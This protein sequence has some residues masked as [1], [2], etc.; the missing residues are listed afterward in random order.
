MINRAIIRPLIFVLTVLGCDLILLAKVTG[1]EQNDA[2][3]LA[4]LES[5]IVFKDGVPN[6]EESRL[7]VDLKRVRAIA[8]D[9]KNERLQVLAWDVLAAIKDPSQLDFLLD[10]A[11]TRKTND[12][13]FNLSSAIRPQVRSPEDEIKLKPFLGS[14]ERIGDLIPALFNTKNSELINMILNPKN[15]NSGFSVPAVNE[16]IEYRL[17]NNLE[18]DPKLIEPFL[19]AACS[20]PVSDQNASIV[21]GARLGFSW[22]V[23]CLMDLIITAHKGKP[24]SKAKKEEAEEKRIASVN[25]NLILLQK[26]C[27]QDF[28]AGMG[29]STAEVEN[30]FSKCLL[31]WGSHKNDRDSTRAAR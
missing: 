28:G 23:G 30:A 13:W 14:Q 8:L 24:A 12:N 19:V 7:E 26:L 21:L 22:A 25:R 3:Y 5:Q 27:G 10:I 9:E 29:K 6:P 16:F 20:K 31:W 17:K 4:K 1:G 2:E 18:L 15:G 11:A